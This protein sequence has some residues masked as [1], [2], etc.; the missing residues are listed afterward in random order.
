[1]DCSLALR[2]KDALQRNAKSQGQKWLHIQMRL[3]ASGIGNGGRAHCD[4][5]SG[6]GINLAWSGRQK[7]ARGDVRSVGI[8]ACGGA[9]SHMRMCR[10]LADRER[11]RLLAAFLAQRV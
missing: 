4:Q 8:C 7:V 10:Q 11:M 6:R 5:V 9:T 1:M 2:R 3:S